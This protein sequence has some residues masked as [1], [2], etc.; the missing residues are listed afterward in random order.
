MSPPDGDREDGTTEEPSDGPSTLD[1]IRAGF[2]VADYDERERAE[3]R[4]RGWLGGVEIDSL[5]EA[6][7]DDSNRIANAAAKSLGKRGATEAVPELVRQVARPERC[8][9]ADI[10]Q[11]PYAE[12]S[13]LRHD[14]MASAL[15]E[16]DDPAAV[17]PLIEALEQT[18]HEWVAWEIAWVLAELGDPRGL[19]AVEA[20]LEEVRAWDGSGWRYRALVG[21]LE[22]AAARLRETAER[23][24]Q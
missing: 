17:D 8:I 22:R 13:D 19:P 15:V 20:V 6:L 12:A 1:E 18:D 9:A 7:S 11:Y 3:Y 23:E 10:V 2:R 5:I 16:L 4:L 14:E 21:D 24:D